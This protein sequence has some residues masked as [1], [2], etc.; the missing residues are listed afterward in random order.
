MRFPVIIRHRREK[1]TIYGK[2]QG[3]SKVTVCLWIT[4]G[5]KRRQGDCRRPRR[6]ATS[7]DCGNRRRAPRTRSTP[8]KTS[9]ATEQQAASPTL[10]QPK[11]RRLAPPAHASKGRR[12]DSR[13]GRLT[14]ADTKPSAPCVTRRS[15]WRLR[16]AS[17]RQ[18]EAS[19]P[20]PRGLVHASKHHHGTE[21]R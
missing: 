5:G 15:R 11:R 14:T 18:I 8:K 1:A 13:A 3:S 7:E 9:R 2:S 4:E 12:G 10:P 6:V 16:I 17:P 19:P 21:S 20:S